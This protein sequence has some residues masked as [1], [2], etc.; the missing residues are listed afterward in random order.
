MLWKATAAKVIRRQGRKGCVTPPQRACRA[1]RRKAGD[2]FERS[3]S[4]TAQALATNS[5]RQA[6]KRLKDV[7]VTPEQSKWRPARRQPKFFE[8]FFQKSTIRHCYYSKKSS[9]VTEDLKRTFRTCEKKAQ[10]P[11]AALVPFSKRGTVLSYKVLWRRGVNVLAI[12][13]SVFV[14]RLFPRLSKIHILFF[15]DKSRPKL[16]VSERNVSLTYK[17][18]AGVLYSNEP[19]MLATVFSRVAS[20]WEECCFHPPRRHKCPTHRPHWRKY[21]PSVK[22]FA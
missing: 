21:P 11:S 6:T 17:C 10:S 4:L 19:G 9:R 18:R 12:N 3:E 7:L 2:M 16:W 8:Y 14:L 15:A 5:E 20:P 1:M 22:I 13:S